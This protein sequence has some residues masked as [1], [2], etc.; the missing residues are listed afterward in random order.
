MHIGDELVGGDGV[1]KGSAIARHVGAGEPH[2]L[3]VVMLADH[4][5]VMQATDRSD[6]GAVLFQRRERRGEF[7]VFARFLNLPGKRVH[8]VGDIKE[9]AA[10][11]L[12][13]RGIHSHA[14]EK[15]KCNSRSCPAQEGPAADLPF[16]EMDVAHVLNSEVGGCLARLEKVRGDKR[17]DNV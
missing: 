5:R 1:A 17:L 4:H 12:G 15:R 10:F 13:R 7:V 9:H 8:T 14:V 11:G 16:F 2:L 6:V 3:A